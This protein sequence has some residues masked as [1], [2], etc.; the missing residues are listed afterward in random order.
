MVLS[1]FST[2]ILILF[3]PTILYTHLLYPRIT[4]LWHT[5]YFPFAH[6][7]TIIRVIIYFGRKIIDIIIYGRKRKTYYF[8]KKNK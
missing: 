4:F 1:M 8:W 2:K 6:A 7:L 5:L 3:T